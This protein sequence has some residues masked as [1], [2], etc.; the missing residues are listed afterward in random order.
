M[1]ESNEI[2]SDASGKDQPSADQPD[3][4]R[5]SADR[6][7]AQHHSYLR[8]LK[9]GVVLIAMLAVPVAFHAVAAVQSLFNLPAEWVPDSLLEKAEFND[10]AEHFSVAE[11]IMV[12]WEGSDLDSESLRQASEILDPLCEPRR[13]QDASVTLQSQ[14]FASLPEWSADWVRQVRQVCGCDHPLHFAR[15]GDEMLSQMTSRPAN[16]PQAVAIRRLQGTVI[17][18]DGKQTCLIISLAEPGLRNR[19]DLIPA[20]RQMVARLVDRPWNQIAVVGGAFEGAEVDAEAI[21]TIKMFSP[22]AAI[23]ATI[24][25]F[26]CLRSIPLTLAIVSVAGLGACLVLAVVYYTGNPMNAVLIVLPPLVFVLTVSAG[27][28]LSNYYLDITSEF[29]GMSPSE[30]AAAAMRAGV[31][32]CCLATGTTIVGLLSLTLVRIGPVRIFGGVASV[33]VA[34]TLALLILDPSRRNGVD[35]AAAVQGG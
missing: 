19:R 14:Q 35:Q 20:I 4:D 8:R 2:A 11:L 15:P 33:G 31:A 7:N 30:A 21:R 25:C 5:P 29:P 1:S 24:L 27:I 10:F 26:L 13:G 9:F 22:P 3:A 34:I 28:H 32:P 12:A 18:P 23:I 16:I 6:L 17:G